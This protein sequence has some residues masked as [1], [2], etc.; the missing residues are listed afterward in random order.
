[1]KKFGILLIFGGK[2]AEHEVSIRS[3]Q[4]VYRA[5]DKKKYA[6][7]LVGI[8]KKGFWK[9]VNAADFDKIAERPAMLN[10]IK[11]NVTFLFG[12]EGKIIFEN[13]TVAS[14][15]IDVVFP[16]LHG[17]NGED[18]AIQGLLKLSNIPFVG[19]GIAGSAVGMDKDI[20]KRLL[21]ETGIP[22]ADFL[23][24]NK[25]ETKNIR[26]E[27]VKKKLG[28]PV[29]VKPANLGSSVGISKINRKEDFKK[30]VSQAFRYDTKIIIEKNISGREIECSILGNDNP[31]ASLPGEVVSNQ[32]FFSYTAKYLDKKGAE[33]LI[34]ADLPK[35]TIKKIQTLAVKTFET[36]CCAGMGRV[37]FFLEKN[38]EILVNEINTI[39]GF[40]SVS[41]YPKLWEASGIKYP[42]LIN[43]LIKLAIE[44]FNEEKK[45]SSSF[46]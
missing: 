41:M 20:M 27:N 34:P 31:I 10:K 26:F 9:K 7:T 39:P 13:G 3:A 12:K 29:F 8:D 4:S 6:V 43:R 45:L 28:L 1:M 24:F 40:T 46:V 32:D 25:S 11:N 36:L 5:M 16:A 15:K 42:D 19:P 17:T 30:A 33:L 23:V 2:S 14:G 38:G 35:D 18:G 37:D 44:R 22:I 21:K